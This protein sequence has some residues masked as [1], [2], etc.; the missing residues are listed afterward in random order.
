MIANP[1][2]HSSWY[3]SGNFA[4]CKYNYTMTKFCCPQVWFRNVWPREP[5]TCTQHASSTGLESKCGKDMA[6]SSGGKALS[7]HGKG[8]PGF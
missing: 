3:A 8:K 2:S 1:T 7:K 6:I 4:Y 5:E